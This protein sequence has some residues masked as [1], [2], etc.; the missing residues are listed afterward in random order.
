MLKAAP[1]IILLV[2]GCG[3]TNRAGDSPQ[4]APAP[5]Q[6]AATQAAEPAAQPVA[7]DEKTDLLEFHLGWPA[8]ISAIPALAAKLRSDAMAHKAELLETAAEDKKARAKESFP[9]NPYDFGEDV[10][11]EGNGGRLLS[12]ALNWY[13]FTGGAHPNHGTRALLWDRAAGREI[14][15]TD[16]FEG[17]APR[18]EG[19]L[20]PA[21]CTALDKARAEKRGPDDSAS[22]VGPDDP[23]NQCP[24]L[25]ELAL[26]PGGAAG[27]PMTKVIIH[28][29]PYVAGP[30]AEGDYDVELPVTS[31]VLTALKPE[32][33]SSF[34]Q[35]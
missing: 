35:P 34:A 24:K 8:E 33:R 4:S 15:F 22:V 28:A 21:F 11:I 12:A 27:H 17:G 14:A 29:D 10:E 5:S 6:S 31:A 1:L 30:Y 7:I 18:L 20:K 32:Y 25:S 19:L 2:A 23:F 13:E 9:F 3:N 16:L 26:I